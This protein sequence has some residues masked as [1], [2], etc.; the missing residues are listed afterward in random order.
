MRRSWLGL[1]P[2]LALVAGPAGATPRYAMKVGQKC[3]LCHTNPTGG[4]QR[5]PYA[6]QYLLPAR[7][8]VKRGDEEPETH[9]PT[10]GD[11]V[12]LGADLRTFWLRSTAESGRTGFAEM[13]GSIYL[14]LQLDARFSAYVHQE[15]GTGFG[16]AAEIFGLGW[17]L[18][19]GGYVKV[20]RFVP[21][22]GWKTADHRSFARRELVWLPGFPPH[23]DTGLEVGLHPGGFALNASVVNGAAQSAFD[24][25]DRLAFVGRG[26]W[27]TGVGGANL[28]VGGSYFF[29]ETTE[30]R[31][32]YG[33]FA[34]IHWKR[35]TWLG[36]VDWTRVDPTA[37]AVVTA[38]TAT[39]ELAVELVQGVDVY[40]TYDFHDPDLD[41]KSG[42]VHR[43]GGGVD[44]LPYPFLALRVA[45]HWYEVDG[46]PSDDALEAT[47]LTEDYRE[48]HV[49]VQILY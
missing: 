5:D 28:A 20:G 14:K 42:A 16:P 25:D 21:A 48:G 44:T 47:G 49:Q 43:I 19:A 1:L 6:T 27:R 17:V 2:A 32:A 18:P 15:L 26:S 10:I 36:E 7:L 46:P 12:T 38:I 33:P 13:Q 41:R 31:Q 3:S 23:S 22:F 24:R 39:N 30:E 37:G 11:H 8:A 4:G 35:L 40:G 9:D 45:G 29:N 34:G